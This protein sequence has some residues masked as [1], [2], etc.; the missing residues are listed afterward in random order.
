MEEIQC[1]L[2]IIFFVTFAISASAT[3][4]KNVDKNSSISNNTLQIAAKIKDIVPNL[5]HSGKENISEKPATNHV[6]VTNNVVKQSSN[7]TT[8]MTSGGENLSDNHV[9]KNIGKNGTLLKTKN[10][11]SASNMD[12][13]L[14]SSAKTVQPLTLKTSIPTSTS[15]PIAKKPLVTVHD[16]D[17]EKINSQLSEKSIPPYNVMN[18]DPL[19]SEK[20]H[21]RSNYIVPIVAVILSVPLVAGI[22]SILYK[23][24]KDWWLHRNYRRM[25]YLIEGL[26]NS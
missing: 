9:T 18:I 15:K 26:Y 16:D 5:T 23:R 4:I 17:A 21:K 11:T 14:P 6:N 20:Q 1:P 2:L 10:S 3:D 12:N 13:S 7:K 24:G 25:D 22:I 19:L 8:N